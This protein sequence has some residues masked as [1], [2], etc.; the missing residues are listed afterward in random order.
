[1]LEKKIIGILCW[2]VVRFLD[3]E[4]ALK[5]VKLV[6]ASN[7]PA[8]PQ[9][10]VYTPSHVQAH[11]K[12]H[13]ILTSDSFREQATLTKRPLICSSPTILLAIETISVRA[14][15]LFQN[16]AKEDKIPIKTKLEKR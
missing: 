4:T 1:M 7:F 15:T 9:F 3:S 13:G 5:N 8:K 6:L 2:K 11:A 16:K 14:R 12:H 10:C